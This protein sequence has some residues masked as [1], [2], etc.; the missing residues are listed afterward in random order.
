MLTN[1]K[2]FYAEYLLRELRGAASLPYPRR[3]KTGGILVLASC[4]RRIRPF[5]DTKVFVLVPLL[6]CFYFERQEATSC[7]S[8][9]V[10]RILRLKM[11]SIGP[12]FSASP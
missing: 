3:K 6:G 10:C 2:S 1:C 9:S 7:V 12:S 11:A 4:G 8:P 5:T